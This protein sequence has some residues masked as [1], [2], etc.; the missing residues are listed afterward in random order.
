MR[1]YSSDER[2]FARQFGLTPAGLRTL[3][4]GA[5]NEGY[6]VTGAG[7]GHEAEGA[8]RRLADQGLIA[9]EA[10]TPAGIDLAARIRAA[11]F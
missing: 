7:M 11:G 1:N 2:T 5:S 6:R 8:R 3:M 4:R 10:L 9:A